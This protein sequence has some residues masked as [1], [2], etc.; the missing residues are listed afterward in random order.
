MPQKPMKFK[1]QIQH[2]L[3]AIISLF[4]AISGLF[5]DHWRDQISEH[6]QN[7]RA[8]AFE[9][10]Q[11]LG[12]LQ[13]VVNYAHFDHNQERGSAIEGWKYAVQVKDLSQLLDNNSAAKSQ[14]LYDTWQQ[15]WEDLHTS[16]E[17]EAKVSQ[18]ISH[19]RSAVLQAIHQIE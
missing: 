13:T 9:V 8:A 16:K 3:V 6:N 11:S 4:A 5:Y 14:L 12:E 7:M 19:A 2:N 10:L 17:S 18:K 15:E 1:Q